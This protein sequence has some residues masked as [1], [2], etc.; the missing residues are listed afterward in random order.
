MEWKEKFGEV[1][2]KKILQAAK[3]SLKK[4]EGKKAFEYLKKK[5]GFSDLIIDKFEFGYCP[6]YIN[7]QLKGRIITPIYDSYGELIAL[8]TRY[9]DKKY[10]KKF[11][12]EIFD[13]RFYLYGLIYA[14]NN[15]IKYQ[16][17]I[18]VEGQFDVASAHTYGFN[19]TVASLG[20]AFTLS[21]A[22]LLSRYCSDVYFVFDGD[23]AG[24]EATKKV[25]KLYKKYNLASFEIRYIPVFLP[26]GM[27]PNDYLNKEGKD[28]F[29][30]ILV[31][32]KEDYT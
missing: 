19:M 9:L 26:L 18:V 28:N 4:D 32:A 20:T 10:F 27:D 31:K 16:K 13:K 29:K 25:L 3:R 22:A 6:P 7:H 11:W 12:H 24:R 21:Q 14:K 30:K 23:K 1:E 5:R 2:R 17:A 8:S 15:I